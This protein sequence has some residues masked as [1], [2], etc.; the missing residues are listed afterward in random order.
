MPAEASAAAS[1]S[2]VAYQLLVEAIEAGHFTPGARMREAEVGA[3]LGLGRTPV[4]DALRKLEAE[5]M[6]EHRPRLGAVLRMLADT[7]V[8]ELYEMRMVLERTAA[9]LAA[10]RATALEVDEVADLNAEILA[11]RS[12]LSKAARINVSFHRALF[13]AARNRFLLDAARG[14][15]NALLL[16]GPSTFDSDTRIDVVHAE[17]ER[18]VDALKT[19][20][21]DEAGA[22]MS[23]HLE[24][25]LRHRLRAL[26]G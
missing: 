24:T 16:L 11:A 22:A 9:E 18:I 26:R 23:A 17:H 3:L 10:Q 19:R 25:S 12:D 14:L 8:V 5:G 7:E 15:N 20:D 6:V 21:G 4:R 13:R 2:E 1:Q